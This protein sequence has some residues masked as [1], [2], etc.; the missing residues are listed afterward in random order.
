MFTSW[1]GSGTRYFSAGIKYATQFYKIKK[2]GISLL[3]K[4]A[5]QS[6]SILSSYAG[7]CGLMLEIPYP[8][9]KIKL[10]K[11]KSGVW[12]F[13]KSTIFIPA[14]LLDCDDPEYWALSLFSF[15][16]EIGHSKDSRQKCAV[17]IIEQWK[18]S[19][20]EKTLK[21]IFNGVPCLNRFRKIFAK[22]WMLCP[23]AEIYAQK[24][25]TEILKDLKIMPGKKI[26]VRE[27]KRFSE[28][29]VAILKT[30]KKCAK[31]LKAGKCPY[32]TWPETIQVIDYGI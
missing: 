14:I 28:Y 32:L 8:P 13:W 10:N 16:H 31:K 12:A 23:T 22:R 24:Q 30:N 18:I 11:K 1:I 15:A 2:Y 27:K 17:A 25:G 20:V 7:S 5:P 21:K 6:Y 29:L 3:L 26:L 9:Q 19:R 4:K